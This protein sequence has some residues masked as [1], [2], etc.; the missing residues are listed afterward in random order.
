M[1]QSDARA[2]AST[3][4]ATSTSA[5]VGTSVRQLA[6]ACPRCGAAVPSAGSDFCEACSA[7]LYPGYCVFCLEPYAPGQAHCRQCGLP[8]EG[9]ICAAAKGARS[10]EE[11]ARVRALAE[12]AAQDALL[13]VSTRS[14]PSAQ[15]ARAV[16]GPTVVL[17]PRRGGAAGPS[18]AA[19]P[20]AKPSSPSPAGT[21][22]SPAHR[23]VSGPLP[24][25]RGREVPG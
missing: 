20:A 19:P 16:V 7:H 18:P 11:K 10:A 5:A 23:P 22:S 1:S 4:A 15:E 21:A 8:P 9:V 2:A 6:T 13:S 17:P 3:V 24:T 25:S 12:Q 14:F